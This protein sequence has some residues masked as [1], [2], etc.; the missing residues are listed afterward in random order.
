MT[1]MGEVV[2]IA[3]SAALAEGIRQVLGHRERYF[4][5]RAE[6]VEVFGLDMTV[7]AYEQL[8]DRLRSDRRGEQTGDLD[9][10]A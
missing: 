1:G 5:T 2:A 7:A 9:A 3:D 6:I 4:R 8:F 10:H